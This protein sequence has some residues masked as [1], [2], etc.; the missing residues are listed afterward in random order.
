[1]KKIIPSRHIVS[2]VRKI[3]KNSSHFINELSPYLG[4][5]QAKLIIRR[6][7]YFLRKIGQVY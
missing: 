7:R 2:K 3:A 5:F 1:M 4:H 6:M